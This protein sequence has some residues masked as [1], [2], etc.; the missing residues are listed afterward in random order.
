MA[1]SVE[2]ECRNTGRTHFPKGVIP[3]NKGKKMSDEYRQTVSKVMMGRPSPR[4]GVKLSDEIKKKISVKV[5]ET[6]IGNKRNVG[7]KW[8][9][10]HYESLWRKDGESNGIPFDYRSNQGY[11]ELWG[12]IRKHIYQRDG[13]VCQLCGAP[14]VKLEC[15]H[16]DYNKSN[17]AFNNLIS[18]CRSCHA[19][20]N[21]NRMDWIELLKAKIINS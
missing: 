19:K 11:D 4:K 17:N 16:I 9:Q 13:Y 3:W 10:K 2:G 18:L 7:K 21:F 5:S 6:L 20:T 1:Y 12:Y 8:T 15:H 14:E